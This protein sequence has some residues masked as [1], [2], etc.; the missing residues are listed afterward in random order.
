VSERGEREAGPGKRTETVTG[1]APRA[2]DQGGRGRPQDHDRA[3]TDAPP[4]GAGR[5]AHGRGRDQGRGDRGSASWHAVEDEGSFLP[6]LEIPLREGAGPVSPRNRQHQAA[7]VVWYSSAVASYPALSRRKTW[8]RGR[9]QL[10]TMR[11]FQ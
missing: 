8:R 5:R 11:P 7:A 2:Q 9:R 4:R 6:K 3:A 1:E 10:D